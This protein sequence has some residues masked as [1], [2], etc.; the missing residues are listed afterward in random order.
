MMLCDS[1]AVTPD[2][3]L[4]PEQV[5]DYVASKIARYKR[6]KWVEFTPAL[7]KNAQGLI[8]RAGVKSTWG[9]VT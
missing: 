3:H 4:T 9:D 5:I 6:P 8:D 1:S 2:T 7:P